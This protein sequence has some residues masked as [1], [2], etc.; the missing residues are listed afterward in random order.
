MLMRWYDTRIMPVWMACLEPAQR[1]QFTAT[2][3]TINFLDRFGNDT[4]LFSTQQV[5]AP[6]KSPAFGKQVI[7]LDDRQFA[8]LMNASDLDTLI[9]HLRRVITDETNLVPEKEL[10]EF[11]GKYLDIARAAGIDDLDRQTQVALLALYTSGKG[12]EHPRF[13]AILDHPP[14]GID[15]FHAEMDQ[16]P[17]EVWEAGPPVWGAAHQ[18]APF[19]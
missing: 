11:V 10:F 19:A 18:N 5:S 9:K 2:L 15:A 8:M 4:L 14:P 16:L 6:L 12:I 17:D 7:Y 13:Q 1:G 3:L